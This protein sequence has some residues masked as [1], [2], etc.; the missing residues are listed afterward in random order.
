[1]FDMLFIIQ[2]FLVDLPDTWEDF[3][4]LWKFS[5]PNT[6]DTKTL[7]LATNVLKKIELNNVF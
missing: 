4:I 3:S 7:A 2:Q 1:M 5:F 6:Y